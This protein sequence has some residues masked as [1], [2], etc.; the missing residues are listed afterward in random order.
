LARLHIDRVKLHAFIMIAGFTGMRST[1]LNNMRWGDIGERTVEHDRDLKYAATVIQVRG[2]GKEREIGGTVLD[3]VI[4]P[5]VVGSFGSE[6]N[7]GAVVQPEPSFLL[8]LLRNL[9]PFTS[10]DALDPFVVHL[11]ACV[12]QQA[13]D[14][15]VAIAPVLIGQLDDIVSQTLFVGLA[16]GRLALRGSMLAQCTAGPALRYAQFLPH[17]VNALAATRRAQKFPLAASVRMS[18]S[19]VRSETARRSRWFS[20]SSSFSRASCDRCIPP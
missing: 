16:L 15:A 12:V 14:H 8:L 2:K 13:G 7:A 19:S 9:Q 1:E 10:P 3:E 6:P 17:L 4:R 11:P 20:F 18:L 5:D